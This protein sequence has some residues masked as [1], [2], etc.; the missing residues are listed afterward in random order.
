MASIP[1]RKKVAIVTSVRNEGLAILDWLAH[2]RATGFDQFFV[3]TNDNTDGSDHL[4]QTL[5]DYG[6]ISLIQNTV[7]AGTKI[8]AKILEHSLHLLTALREFEWAFYIDVDEFFISRCEPGLTLDSFFQCFSKAFPSEPPSAVC[9]NWKWFGSENAF[10]QTDGLLM[11]RFVHSIHNGHVKSLVRLR[12]VVSMHRVHV[13]VLVNNGWLAN[14][15]FDR[16]DPAI[17]MKPT[18]GKG[19]INHYWNKSFQEFVLK[20]ARGRISRGFGGEPL[21]FASFFDWGANGRRGNLDRPDSR[22]IDRA[23]REYNSLLSI[24]QVD[25]NLKAI[26]SCHEKML[27]DLDRDLDIA[28]IY[29]RRGRLA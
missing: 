8:Q 7:A 25:E 19:Q 4:L 14:S 15:D 21:D 1:T 28:G 5:A 22:V 12:D 13:P 27:D 29:E 24:P 18:Y 2:C 20:R 11:E 23:R 26:R 10:E 16:V 9:F 17:E 3:Y 6:V